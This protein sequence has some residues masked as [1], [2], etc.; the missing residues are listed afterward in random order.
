[1]REFL[2]Y[3]TFNVAGM[4]SISCYILA[5]TF[6]ISNALGATGLTA[7]NLAIP[8]YS[9]IHGV[10]LLLGIGGAT[11]FTLRHSRGDRQ[12]ANAVFTHTVLLWAVCSLFFELF[13]AFGSDALT[14]WMGADAAVWDM[15]WIYLRVLLLNAPMFLLNDILLCFV[16]NDGAPRRA[17]TGMVAGSFS[18]I[19]LDYVMIY[20]LQMGMLGA[21]V[22]TSLAP[23]ISIA[24]LLVHLCSQK[25][26]F[27]LIHT[28]FRPHFWRRIAGTG[29]YSMVTELSSAVVIIVFNAII[30]RLMGNIGVAAYGVVANLSLV[31][32]AIYT[33][34]AQG[35]QPLVSRSCGLGKS[36]ET[37]RT[38]RR[39]I[40]TALVLSVVLYGGAFLAADAITSVFNSQRDPLLQKTAVEGLRIYFA[41]CPFLGCNIVLS[42]FF[43]ASDR[44]VPAGVLS[45][46]R[47]FVVILPLAF[48]LSAWGGMRGLWA[49]FPATEA[50]VCLVA[51]E[52]L[53]LTKNRLHLG[54]KL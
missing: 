3:V 54:G 45:L 37:R 34:V 48:L 2:R 41:A 49:V 25:R 35:I 23:F 4:L 16:R 30:L 53:C 26:T 21:V 44:P 28:P 42:G 15:T 5:D 9:V 17:T 50:L 32:V 46:L 7:L 20:P 10:G 13:G 11:H 27:R 40:L 36:Y 43:S 52:L 24:C 14:R 31:V 51:V 33:G 18:N 38:L 29:L 22:A 39:A 47:G 6:F 1:M 19:L 12:G 8:I